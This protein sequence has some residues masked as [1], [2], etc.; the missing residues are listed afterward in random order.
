MLVVI[1]EAMKVDWHSKFII[2][3][4]DGNARHRVSSGPAVTALS[5]GPSLRLGFS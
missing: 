4:F 5:C 2:I 3:N 1:M